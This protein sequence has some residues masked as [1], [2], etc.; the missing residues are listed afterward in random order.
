LTETKKFSE[1]KESLRHGTTWCDFH[2]REYEFCKGF[3]AGKNSIDWNK[4]IT[5]HKKAWEEQARQ[6][7]A[8]KAITIIHRNSVPEGMG[9]YGAFISDENWNKIRKELREEALKKEKLKK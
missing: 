1:C 5:M 6:D 8:E 4:E 3:K 9:H 2:D 7:F